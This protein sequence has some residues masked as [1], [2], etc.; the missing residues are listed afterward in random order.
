VRDSASCELIKENI[1]PFKIRRIVT[2]HDAN[3]KA[4]I[5]MDSLIESK[6]GLKDKNVQNAPLW[7]TDTAPASNTTPGD[8]IEGKMQLSPP[9]NGSVFRMLELP[10]NT[11]ALM[12][13]TETLDYVLMMEGECD[14]ILDDGKEVHMNQ[15][16]VMIQRGTWHGWANRSSK[17]CR[18]AFVLVDAVKLGAIGGHETS[19]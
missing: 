17:T 13:R 16:D 19:H 8:P 10:P 2:T 5:G 3:G 4:I 15:G 12:H 1:M 9:P 6:P 7:V 18:I 14:M 11:P